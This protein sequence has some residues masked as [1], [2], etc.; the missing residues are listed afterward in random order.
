MQQMKH[1]ADLSHTD[2]VAL[3]IRALQ[4]HQGYSGT[5]MSLVGLLELTRQIRAHIKRTNKQT[6]IQLTTEHAVIIRDGYRNPVFNR[7]RV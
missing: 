2:K 4:R 7:S 6:Y 1:H 3:W 5:C